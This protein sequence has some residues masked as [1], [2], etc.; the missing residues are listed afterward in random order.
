[1]RSAMERDNEIKE[2]L[3]DRADGVCKCPVLSL[4]IRFLRDMCRSDRYYERGTVMNQITMS[5]TKQNAE[6]TSLVL[7]GIV[8]CG[9]SSI[10]KEFVYRSLDLY[11]IVLY[12]RARDR[13]HLE[14]QFSHLARLLGFLEGDG[15]L[16]VS[17]IRVME[18][19]SQTDSKWLLFFD[20][21]DDK[22]ILKSFWPTA[23][24]GAIIVTSR[25]PLVQDSGLVS[26]RIDITNFD[27]NDGAAFLLSFLD[28]PVS[29]E[30]DDRTAANIIA[31]RYAGWPLGLRNTASFIKDKRLTPA[32]FVKLQNQQS[33]D[34]MLLH[35]C[36]TVADLCQMALSDV[37]D[38]ARELLDFL[39]FLVP[40]QIPTD[41]V[42]S[43]KF[44]FL[45]ARVWLSSRSLISYDDSTD[46]VSVDRSFH[47]GWLR[48][49]E[50]KPERYTCVLRR[51][52]TSLLDVLPEPN[53]IQPRDPE[54]WN[55]Q[56]MYI[57]HVISLLQR[58]HPQIPCDLVCH[59]LNL[60]L[61]AI[62]Y[63]II[64]LI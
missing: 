48:K 36:S 13:V 45:D 18:W 12:F 29:A 9:K 64:L 31:D 42:D 41:F 53:F 28:R 47:E 30:A 1:M 23:T 33:E 61:R 54:L 37:P 15:D 21:A 62:Q 14:R 3:S 17:L 52:I 8:G 58:S 11:D 39:A 16:S 25:D 5:L 24:H 10:A 19:L 49:L 59:L 2:L 44:Q 63:D 60:G 32:R 46:F 50:D 7:C 43:S 20:D 34:N 55:V 40:C 51:V 26:Q 22:A 38:D 27:V 6:M 4:P 35:G 57:M 56:G